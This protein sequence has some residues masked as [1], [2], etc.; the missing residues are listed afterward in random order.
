MRRTAM[1]DQNAAQPSGKAGILA[2]SI[3]NTVRQP[4]LVLNEDL[5]VSFANRAFYDSFRVDRAATVGRL[6][7]D[8]GNRQWDIPRLRELLS[9]IL[10]QDGS[11]EDFEVEQAFESVG[12]RVMLLNARKLPRPAIARHKFSS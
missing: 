10:P 4:I 9:D 11:V 6:I 8:L 3:V 5:K 2:E 7:Y 12:E 1:T